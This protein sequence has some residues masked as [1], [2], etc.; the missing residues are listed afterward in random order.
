MIQANSKDWHGEDYISVSDRST[1]SSQVDH[2]Q[3]FSIFAAV[4]GSDYA[5][6]IKYQGDILYNGITENAA[7]GLFDFLCNHGEISVQEIAQ[8]YIS[9][10]EAAGRTEDE[11]YGLTDEAYN[12]LMT[13]A[14]KTE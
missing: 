12:N 14:G 2:A 13:Y 1:I 8:N 4:D 10:L 6:K 7:E 11:H 3:V 9:D 5:D